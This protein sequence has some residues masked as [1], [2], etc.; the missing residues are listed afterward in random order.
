MQAIIYKSFLPKQE[1]PKSEETSI[2]PPS[3]IYRPQYNWKDQETPQQEDHTPQQEDIQP[4]IQTNS[5]IWTNPEGTTIISDVTNPIYKQSSIIDEANPILEE[6]VPL[7]EPTPK[8]TRGQHQFKSSDIQVGEMQELLDRFAD[9]GISLRITS[10]YRPGATTSS[11][12]QSWHAS[13]YALDITPIA[14]QTYED[15]KQQLRDNPDLVKWM[16]DNGF[17][18]IDETTPEMQSRT[19]ATGAHWHIGKDK[20]AQSGLR[21]IISAHSGIK[22]P[23]IYAKPGHKLKKQRNRVTEQLLSINHPRYRDPLTNTDKPLE[24]VSI[25]SILPGTGDVAEG[26]SIINDISKGNIGSALL[27]TTLFLIPGNIPQILRKRPKNIDNVIEFET[28]IPERLNTGAIKRTHLPEKVGDKPIVDAMLDVPIEMGDSKGKGALYDIEKDQIILDHN[29]KESLYPE[30]I[31]HEWSH[32][33]DYQSPNIL[34]TL[35]TSDFTKIPQVYLQKGVP[36]D[37]FSPNFYGTKVTTEVGPRLTQLLD[38]LKISDGNKV[39][40]WKEWNKAMND[41]IREHPINN[42]KILQESI[43]DESLFTKWAETNSK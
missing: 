10:G 22:L 30:A 29:L 25:A 11:G 43:T 9:A 33:L 19:G 6:S 21:D 39:L 16:Q 7:I 23:I 18:I 2:S 1:T 26:A 5:P 15:L 28:F 40:N 3:G 4:V 35:G 32:W 42:I 14:G 41:Y 13:G 37:Y 34:N 20:L 8:R 27:G 24:P 36:E 38:Y 12:N 17:G 31:R